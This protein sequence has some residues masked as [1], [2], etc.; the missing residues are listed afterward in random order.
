MLEAI[1]KS[2]EVAPEFQPIFAQ[3]S[4]EFSGKYEIWRR[5]EDFGRCLSAAVLN[6]STQVAAAIGLKKGTIKRTTLLSPSE[7][8]KIRE[9][10][11]SGLHEDLSL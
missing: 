8:L 11:A 7:I 10:L 1:Y 5:V 4:E 9:H 3:L 6:P 2:G